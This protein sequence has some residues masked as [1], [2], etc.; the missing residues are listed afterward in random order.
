MNKHQTHFKPT[1]LVKDK[2]SDEYKRKL[3][4][5]VTYKIDELKWTAH[6]YIKEN[7]LYTGKEMMTL[8]TVAEFEFY[9]DVKNEIWVNKIISYGVYQGIGIG[10]E[11][12]R[13]AI[14]KFGKVYFTNAT[15][16]ENALFSKDKMYDFR[17][18]SDVVNFEESNIG[19]FA[20]SLEKKGVIEFSHIKNPF[21]PIQ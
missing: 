10:T 17:Y 7:D 13:Q 2:L 21:K 9:K 6:A 1:Q 19:L 4:Q 5:S 8:E 12:I 18:C 14:N 3:L 11:I 16:E 20:L 15:Q